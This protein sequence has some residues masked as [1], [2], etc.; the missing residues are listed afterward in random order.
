MKDDHYISLNGAL[1]KSS[2][3]V[4]SPENRAMMYGDGCFETLKSYQGRFLNWEQHMQRLKG[5]LD[6]LDLE[7][8]F[9]PEALKREVLDVIDANHLTD[10]EAMI[11][12]QFWR[13]GG[14]GYKSLSHKTSRMVQ[15]KTYKMPTAPLNLIF[16]KTRCI[17]SESLE[18]KYKLSNSLN[19]IKAAQEANRQQ[20]DDAVMLTVN[21]FV[22]EITIANL[23]WIKSEAV[24]TPSE[25]CD[26]LPGVTRKIMMDLFNEMGY[27]VKAGQFEKETLLEAEAVFCTN[28]LMELQEIRSIDDTTFNTA[29]PLIEEL[30]ET[31]QTFK[32]NN[33]KS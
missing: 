6:Y 9:D 29:H 30:R 28:S 25:E 21:G 5:G 22:S 27:P 8:L 4:V 16:A 17:P 20:R 11:R 10:D 12:I 24:V 13:E 14:R 1:L 3:A 2:E 33:M 7:S 15:A 19:Y 32:E 18:R 23:F 31:F 26:I